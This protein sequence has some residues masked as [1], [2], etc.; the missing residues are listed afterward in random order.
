MSHLDESPR[1]A[2]AM[3][4]VIWVFWFLNQFFCLIILLNF[5]I[6]IVSESYEEIVSES[7]TFMYEHRA[8]MNTESR[9]PFKK[10][11]K[12]KIA[13]NVDCIVITCSTPEEDGGDLAGLVNTIKGH[14]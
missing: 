8:Q 14:I 1:T 4:G 3:I 9:L 10:F 13:R 2:N 7:L 11:M 6:A 12:H 5:L